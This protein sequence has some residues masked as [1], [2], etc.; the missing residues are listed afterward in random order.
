MFKQ[1]LTGSVV[2]DFFIKVTQ[3]AIFENFIMACIVLNTIVL[4]IKWY[5]MSEAVINVIQ[6]INYVFMVIFT[7]EAIIKIFAL[8][9]NYFKEAWNIFDF[10]VVVGTLIILVIGFLH[11][12]NF[13]IQS[14]I[15]RSMRIGRILRILRQ[16]KK[17][18]IIFNTLVEAL[19]SMASLGMLLLLLM[20]M[21]AIIGMSQFG[22]ANITD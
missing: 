11:L 13:G 19:P 1:Q 16:F 18:Q 17:L 4:M 14:T 9:S 20:F 22:F 5:A 15:L 7:L 10:T 6:L 2:R 21:Y 8:R 12:G 3:H